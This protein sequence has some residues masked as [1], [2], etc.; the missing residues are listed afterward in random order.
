MGGERRRREVRA[1]SSRCRATVPMHPTVPTRPPHHTHTLLYCT[2]LQ[3]TNQPPMQ[4]V[5]GPRHEG[6]QRKG[7]WGRESIP[8]LPGVRACLRLCVCVCVYSVLVFMIL[9]SFFLY[10]LTYQAFVYPSLHYHGIQTLL[11][12]SSIWYRNQYIYIRVITHDYFLNLLPGHH[13]I[14]LFFFSPI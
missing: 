11:L 4:S 10:K 12:S 7:R 13:R 5:S 3:P 2:P 6:E 14:L 1:A 9:G 8:P